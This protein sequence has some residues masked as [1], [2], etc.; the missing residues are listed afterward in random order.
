MLFNKLRNFC[1]RNFDPQRSSF[2]TRTVNFRFEFK[3]KILKLLNANEEEQSIFNFLIKNLI[4]F[5]GLIRELSRPWRSREAAE[6]FLQKNLAQE[7]S[8]WFPKFG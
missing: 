1:I 2:Q 4:S 7:N 8:A 3:F 5:G 6:R